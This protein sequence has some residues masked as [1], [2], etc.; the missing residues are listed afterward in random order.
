MSGMEIFITGL[1][2]WGALNALLLLFLAGATKKG[3]E[4]ERV[5]KSVPC[6]VPGCALC[7]QK[8]K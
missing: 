7:R 6:N 5:G 4:A 8:E 3:N 2:A 1:I